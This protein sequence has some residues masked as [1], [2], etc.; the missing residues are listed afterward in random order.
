MAKRH[1]PGSHRHSQH[2]HIGRKAGPSSIIAILLFVGCCSAGSSSRIEATRSYLVSPVHLGITTPSLALAAL[3]DSIPA[4]ADCSGCAVFV[5]IFG[6]HLARDHN[7]EVQ[8][9]NLGISGW[10]SEDLL[11][12]LDPGGA[13]SETVSESD[14]ITVTIGANDF[15]AGLDSYLDGN[16]GGEDRLDCFA[17]ALPQLTRTL[18][19]VLQR[20]ANLRAGRHTRVF[21]TGYWDVFPDG[22]VAKGLY[23]AQFVEDSNVLT[24]RA[25]AVID[26]VSA[27]QGATFVDLFTA[28]KGSTGDAD[29][30]A[31]LADDGDHPNQAGHQKI[32]DALVA[33]EA[34]SSAP[35]RR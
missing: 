19:A 22:D 33:V 18:T 6:R 14:M 32:S 8:I 20:I 12:S 30:T 24:Q 31:L 21:V 7:V 9:D 23:G 25:N 27:A 2:G 1:A 29:P 11:D 13:D 26:S 17:P 16:C 34:A 35:T 3:G 15:Y 5:E 4:G 28:F 10:T